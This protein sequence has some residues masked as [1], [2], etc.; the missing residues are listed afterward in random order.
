MCVESRKT[1]EN[2]K[3]KQFN[4]HSSPQYSSNEH[5]S[6]PLKATVLTTNSPATHHPL[7]TNSPPTHHRTHHQLT[8]HSP[9]THHQL[10]SHSPPTHHPLTT[11]SPPYSPPT[12]H[13][14]TIHSPPTH[15]P[16]TIHSLPVHHTNSPTTH[17]P[18]TI[19]SLAIHHPLTIPSP[20]SMLTT[21]RS[22]FST[23]CT[24]LHLSELDSY[25][26]GSSPGAWRIDMHTLPSLYTVHSVAKDLR[27][28]LI[29]NFLFFWI[30]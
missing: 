21:L 13:P 4:F 10:T 20:A 26:I 18:L 28:H 27:G 9:P 24:G 12:H 3:T 2:W 8:S 22:I 19:H 11:H 14:L 16:L 23:L 30:L 6:E 1:R 25:P 17:H 5:T 7:T 29:I 15:H